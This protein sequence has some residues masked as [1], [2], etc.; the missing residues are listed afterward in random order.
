MTQRESHL[1]W[2]K[3]LLDHLRDCHEQLQWADDP[4]TARLLLE[5]MVG[6]LDSGKRLCEALKP[7]TPSGGRRTLSRAV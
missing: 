5:S 4:E 3:D 1:L 2:L 6:D 7:R